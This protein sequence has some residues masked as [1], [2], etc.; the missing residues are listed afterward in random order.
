MVA[1]N[2]AEGNGYRSGAP[3]ALAFDPEVTTGPVVILPVALALRLSGLGATTAN[4]A[5]ALL[6]LALLAICLTLL[7]RSGPNGPLVAA[8]TALLLLARAAPGEPWPYGFWFTALGEVPGLLLVIAGLLLWCEE[9]RVAGS[10]AMG[11]AL[12]CKISFAPV[13]A[14]GLLAAQA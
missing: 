4:V 8:G 7:A 5:A 11:A 9:K 6:S 10:L 13:V 1:R 3:H 12:L 14:A 2:L